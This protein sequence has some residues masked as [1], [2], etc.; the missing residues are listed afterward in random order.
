MLQTTLGRVTIFFAVVATFCAGMFLIAAWTVKDAF[1]YEP[2]LRVGLLDVSAVQAKGVMVFDVETGTEI[3]S[4]RS[5]D[6]LPVASIT[7]LLTAALFY[8]DADLTGSTTI[9]WSD[10]NTY[11][12]AGRIHAFEEYSH[13]ELLFPLLLESSNDAA[14]AMGRVH[15]NLLEDMN[16]Y[17]LSLGLLNT[18][19][20]DTSGLSENNVSTAYELSILSATLYKKFPHIIDI[21][22]LGQYI[23]THTGWLNNNP[24]VDEPRYRGGKHGFTEAANRTD[25]AFFEETLRSGH[26]R[27]IGYVVLGTDSVP[28]DIARLRDEV[29]RNVYVE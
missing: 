22:R 19:F 8:R 9:T 15:S 21:T 3:A 12:D 18:S 24:L 29:Q 16:T 23:G 28:L 6:V 14:A 5:T 17:A 27:L 10:V 7:K 13:R 1:E 11:G 25:V 20:A 26:T 2:Q 4:R